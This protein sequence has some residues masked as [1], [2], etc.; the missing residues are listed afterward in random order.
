MQG[1]KDYK[2]TWGVVP[3]R[4]ALADGDIFTKLSALVMGLGNFARKQ[5]I[6]GI[7]FLAAEVAFIYYLIEYGVQSIINFT[8]LG[9]KTQE[10]VF[11]EAT[12]LYE[13]TSGDN[14]LLFLLGGVV[15]LFV[16]LAFIVV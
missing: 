6:Q 11:N 2:L 4:Q 9:T 7:L 3:L 15:T 13:Y 16:I 10:K 14:S 12:Q 1:N 5:W 8:T